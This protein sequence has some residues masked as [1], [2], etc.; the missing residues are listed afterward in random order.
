MDLEEIKQLVHEDGGKILI[1]ENNKVVAVVL[2]F[3]QYREMRNNAG[4]SS[5][6]SMAAGMQARQAPKPFAEKPAFAPKP[7]EAHV[8]EPRQPF[9]F[10]KAGETQEVRSEETFFPQQG[11]GLAGQALQRG[12]LQ[13]SSAQAIQAPLDE[14]PNDLPE[15]E[16]TI[17]DLPV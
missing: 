15:E 8:N 12:S 5:S 3:E 13:Q 7:Q 6:V 1:V 2:S 11:S 17:D 10:P 4:P 9:G 16:L 14:F